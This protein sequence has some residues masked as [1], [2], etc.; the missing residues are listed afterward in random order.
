MDQNA[1][2]TAVTSHVNVF[3]D[4]KVLNA[5]LI[6][7]TAPQI[8][9]LMVASALIKLM[10]INANVLQEPLDHDASANHAHVLQ[11]HVNLEAVFLVQ[12]QAMDSSVDVTKDGTV[13]I[14]TVLLATI[15]CVKMVAKP[16]QTSSHIPMTHHAVANV[17]KGSLDDIARTPLSVMLLTRVKMVEN[18][19]LSMARPLGVSVKMVLSG[20][21]AKDNRILAKTIHA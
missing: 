5:R 2:L 17:L 4:G 18:A 21:F 7:T 20:N 8:H 11:I 9:A 16:C 15:P 1:L 12:V 14:V 3:L 19:I 6:L 10:D 13:N